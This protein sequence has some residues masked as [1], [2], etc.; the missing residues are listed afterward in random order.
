MSPPE[1]PPERA[2]LELLRERYVADGFQFIAEPAADLL[3]SFLRGYFPDAIALKDG[4]GVVIEVKGTRRPNSES[5]VSELAR[6][7]EGRPEWTLQLVFADNFA[8][9]ELQ[10]AG[11]DAISV[12]SDEEL[13]QIRSEIDLLLDQGHYSAALILAWSALEAL[14]RRFLVS[15]KPSLSRPLTGWQV[16][17]QLAARGLLDRW[18]LD[19]VSRLL[20]R[21][22]AVAHG[23][24]SATVS[25]EEVNRMLEIIDGVMGERV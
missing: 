4:G 10:S 7:L 24:L 6:R 22:N 21:R 12:P 18:P 8:R 17:E 25:R 23:D 15:E 1:S 3:P 20:A 9:S 13:K 16:V 2:I 5:E 11:P 19:D 14:A